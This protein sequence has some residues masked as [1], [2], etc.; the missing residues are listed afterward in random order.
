[1]L[2]HINEIKSDPFRFWVHSS[3]S[4][5]TIIKENLKKRQYS[6]IEKIHVIEIES[7]N[8]TLIALVHEDKD[9]D[10]E[11]L[12]VIRIFI[13]T[14]DIE[15]ILK[16]SNNLELKEYADGKYHICID[17]IKTTHKVNIEELANND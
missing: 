7:K 14:Q 16:F 1:M 17:S 2:K 15:L 10:L 6:D 3:R 13:C 12:N 4:T 8:E 9:D 5:T 11:F